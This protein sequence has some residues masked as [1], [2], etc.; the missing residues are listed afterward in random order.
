MVELLQKAYYLQS[1]KGDEMIR[2]EDMNGIGLAGGVDTEISHTADD[3][4]IT[5]GDASSL[6]GSTLSED[7]ERTG[8]ITSQKDTNKRKQQRSN[9]EQDLEDVHISDEEQL[10]RDG[11]PDGDTIESHRRKP[12]ATNG[13]DDSIIADMALSPKSPVVHDVSVIVMAEDHIRQPEPSRAHGGNKLLST[14]PDLHT[15]SS[16]FL[17]KILQAGFEIAVMGHFV[18]IL[19]SYGLAGPKS[20]AQLM[21]INNFFQLLI[22][23]FVIGL[24]LLVVFGS[25]IISFFISVVTLFKGTLLVVM[26]F[27]V[28]LV[29]LYVNQE[30][31]DNWQFVGRPFLI[32]TIALG[33]TCNTIPLIFSSMTRNGPPSKLN[34]HMFRAGAV[35]GIFTC[36]VLNILWCLFVLRIVPQYGDISLEQAEE[37]GN[38]STVPLVQII[39]TTPELHQFTWIAVLVQIFITTSITVSFVTL[40]SGMKHVL[41]GY[42]K[43]FKLA[44]RRNRRSVLKRIM[45]TLSRCTRH[46][47]TVV[48]FTLYT[49]MYG[50]ILLLALF[51]PKS[52]FIVME[53]FAS[54][55]LNLE[56]GFFIAIMLIV[57]G[58]RKVDIPVKLS[59]WI[60]YLA[61]PVAAYFLFAVVY[62]VFYSIL[63]LAMF[64]AN[65]NDDYVVP[66]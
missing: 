42:V 21:G 56:S 32:S 11:A 54:L 30:P 41:D 62:D 34:V 66:I 7:E 18:S 3:S 20:L 46:P 33:G 24:A 39:E 50:F 10:Q 53:V 1:N 37:E 60:L 15:M 55:A 36:F 40:S 28:G 48:Q 44:A 58:R 9:S 2:L 45:N 31:A 64:F 57:A 19:T 17:P 29:G 35:L 49:L 8:E 6:D 63:R 16:L 26:I 59:R 61:V 5:H 4:E 52:F 14:G 25:R 23:V 13:H 65:G 47:A 12:S 43:S 38:I 22:P 51:N 27:I